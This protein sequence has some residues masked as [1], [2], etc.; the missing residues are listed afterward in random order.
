M[1]YKEVLEVGFLEVVK[2]NIQPV[3]GAVPIAGFFMPI[4][5]SYDG[6]Y[7]QVRAVFLI[8]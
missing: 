1:D 4:S 2:Y 7:G 3:T 6:R 8:V 5:S